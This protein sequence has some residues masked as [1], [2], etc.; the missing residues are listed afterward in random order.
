MKVQSAHRSSDCR[1]SEAV[2][3]KLAALAH[4][5]RI[6][7]LRHLAGRECCCCK[8][9]VGHVNLAQSTVSQHLRVLVEAGLVR[10]S[11]DRQRSRYEVDRDALDRLSDALAHFI[12]SCA[13][14]R[15]P[16][17]TR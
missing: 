10:F 16:D 12:S 5:V 13:D 7:I 1:S 6:E 3:T 15:M 9:V 17:E 11:P 2:A 8:D 4:P 14:V